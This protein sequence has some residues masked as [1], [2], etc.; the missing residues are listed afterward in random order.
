MRD[1]IE[2]HEVFIEDMQRSYR[3][4]INETGL[5]TIS[6]TF[7]YREYDHAESCSNYDWYHL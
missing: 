5:Q 2:R 7:L 3:A 4:N 1:D 6:L